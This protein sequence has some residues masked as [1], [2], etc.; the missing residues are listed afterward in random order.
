MCCYVLCGLL[1]RQSDFIARYGGEEFVVVLHGNPVDDAQIVAEKLRAGIEELALSHSGS[2][3]GVVTLSI[4]V[5]VKIP[6][7][8]D[9]FETLIKQADAAMYR[10][11][12]KGRNDVEC[13]RNQAKIDP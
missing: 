2:P 7:P 9:T 3:Y 1:L 5:V 4:G 10:V 8:Y 11:K 12:A 6:E 13:L